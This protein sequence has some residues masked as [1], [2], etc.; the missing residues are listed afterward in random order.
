MDWAL[1]R[2]AAGWWAGRCE[3]GKVVVSFKWRYIHSARHGA[4]YGIG[5][6]SALPTSY[7]H[8]LLGH[9]GGGGS[10]RFTCLGVWQGNPQVFQ[11]SIYFVDLP[12][13]GPSA[14]ALP[15]PLIQ[16]PCQTA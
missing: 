16:Q 2:E 4:W 15:S 5:A 1:G 14:H 8:G 6:E 11:T 10:T 3:A 7:L 9:A 12:S 13:K